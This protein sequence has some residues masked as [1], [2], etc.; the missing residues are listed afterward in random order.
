MNPLQGTAPNPHDAAV[1]AMADSLAAFLPGRRVTRDLASPLTEDDAALMAGLLCLVAEGGGSWAN[2]QDREGDLGSARARL[3][4]FVRVRDDETSAAV[5]RAEMS[6]L[7]DVMAW[8]QERKAPPLDC[9]YP[10]DYQL[11]RQ[12]EHPYGWFALGVELK[13]L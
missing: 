3:V 12:L 13:Y 6:L 5:E 11:S 9:V 10:G 8:M 7:A 2:W 1:Q 4:G